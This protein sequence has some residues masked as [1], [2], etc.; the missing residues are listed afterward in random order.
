MRFLDRIR[1]E[2]RRAKRRS[3]SEDPSHDVASTRLRRRMKLQ[4]KYCAIPHRLHRIRILLSSRS[5]ASGPTINGQHP[6][7]RMKQIG[8]SY[9]PG[10][11]DVL[12][13]FLLE[14]LA[15]PTY[16]FLWYCVQDL[17]C[18]LGRPLILGSE[19]TNRLESAK[20][21]C[22]SLSLSLAQTGLGVAGLVLLL[23]LFEWRRLGRWWVRG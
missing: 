23:R 6:D 7:P 17:P 16:R 19:P 21:L 11:R 18:C 4:Y 8:S 22:S 3:E 13:I 1:A 20:G 9:G 5:P 2:L 12:G 15:I 14:L 10:P